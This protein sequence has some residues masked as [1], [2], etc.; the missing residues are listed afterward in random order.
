[1]TSDP[2]IREA[3]ADEVDEILALWKAAGSGPS[4]TDTSDHLRM[5]T[6]EMPDL[7]LV[8]ESDGRLVGS[9]IGGW[10]HWRGHI[11][12]LAVHPDYRRQ[13]LARWL[14]SEIEARLR[15]RGAVR[16]YALAATKQEMGVKFW[17]SIPYEKSNDLPYVRTFEE[18]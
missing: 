3:R 8:A 9:V 13:G 10:D 5:L 7:F 14:T 1:V 16:I 17:E 12:R 6:A 18:P 4:V 2:A 15:A 11:Y